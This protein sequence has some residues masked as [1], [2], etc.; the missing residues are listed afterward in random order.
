M[1]PEPENIVPLYEVVLYG[2]LNPALIWVA[3]AMGRKADEPAKLL[4]AA[5]AGAVAGSVL[6]YLAALIG[7]LDAPR[8]ARAAAGVFVLSLA[9]GLVYAWIG[10]RLKG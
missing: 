7:V 1:T 8:V 6:L 9:A 10:Y 2:L 3:F 5:F 4:L